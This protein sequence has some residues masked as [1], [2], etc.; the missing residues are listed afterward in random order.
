MKK[1]DLPDIKNL[2]YKYSKKIENVEFDLQI[3]NKIFFKILLKGSFPNPLF[4]YIDEFNKEGEIKYVATLS[5]V[6]KNSS[7]PK[8][9]YFNYEYHDTIEKAFN[10]IYF[11]GLRYY[12][13]DDQ[14]TVWEEH[15]GFCES[16]I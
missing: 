13:P 8:P 14:S 12:S 15:V 6:F 4:G 16:P 3:S 1:M 7:S 5:H 10:E 2:L 9:Y 11:R